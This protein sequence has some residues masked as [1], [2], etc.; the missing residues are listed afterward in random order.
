MYEVLRKTVWAQF[1]PSLKFILHW[2]LSFKNNFVPFKSLQTR[3][4]LEVQNLNGWFSCPLYDCRVDDDVDTLN[5]LNWSTRTSSRGWVTRSKMSPVVK[6]RLF[7][8]QS[9]YFN[10]F[11][12]C[13]IPSSKR[14]LFTVHP[15]LVNWGGFTKRKMQRYF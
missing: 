8:H 9:I 12:F 4:K 10:K 14:K 6:L 11:P 1:S 5:V 3:S 15:W 13:R 2:S 7:F